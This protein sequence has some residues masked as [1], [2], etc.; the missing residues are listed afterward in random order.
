MCERSSASAVFPA[1]NS[2]RINRQTR[3]FVLITHLLSIRTTL[4]RK[5]LS[6]INSKFEALTLTGN[7]RYHA[8]AS[9]ALNMSYSF[10]QSACSIESRCVV[11]SPYDVYSQYFLQNPIDVSAQ[12]YL[13][14]IGDGVETSKHQHCGQVRLDEKWGVDRLG[15]HLPS[16]ENWKIEIENTL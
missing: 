2:K 6:V 5:M 11:M 9:H 7:P 3:R 12:V 16:Q 15:Q 14:P 4:S 8:F 1:K 10:G 13:H